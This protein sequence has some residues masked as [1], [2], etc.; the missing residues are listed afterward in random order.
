MGDDDEIRYTAPV[1]GNDELSF[2]IM[3][4]RVIGRMD[5][6]AARRVLD[7]LDAKYSELP[8]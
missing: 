6:D 3:A 2:L 4:D 8:F 1:V 5:R 7:W